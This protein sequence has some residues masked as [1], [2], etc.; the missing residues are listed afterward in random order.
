VGYRQTD[1]APQRDW[2]R[3]PPVNKFEFSKRGKWVIQGRRQAVP[4]AMP[5]K[6]T[7][8][9]RAFEL[10]DAGTPFALIRTQLIHEG[11][12]RGHLEGT[13]LRKQLSARIAA[14]KKIPTH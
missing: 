2:L 12:D 6:P 7:A 13:A 14:A 1:Y 4:I 10:A 3:I 5:Q 11:Y 9:E 8:M